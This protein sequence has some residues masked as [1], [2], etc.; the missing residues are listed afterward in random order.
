MNENAVISIDGCTDVHSIPSETLTDQR[1][2][3]ETTRSILVSYTAAVGDYFI[4]MDD[5]CMSYR[6]YLLDDFV[7][8]E[9]IVRIQ[10]TAYF[11][12][13]NPI[14]YSKLFRKF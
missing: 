2:R 13:M 8:E 5:N 9:G 4:L 14:E 6:T 7:F 11:T 3:D 1:Y 12:D 10:R